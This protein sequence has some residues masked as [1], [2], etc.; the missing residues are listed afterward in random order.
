MGECHYQS[1]NYEAMVVAETCRQTLKDIGVEPER[2]SLDWASAAEAPRFV[3]LIT[4]YVKRIKG[5]GALGTGEGEEA[6]PV[7][8]RRLKAAVRAASA[9]KP[10]TSLGTLSKGL[11]K[12]GDYTPEAIEAGVA[13]KVLPAIRQQRITEEVLILLK[14]EGAMDEGHL[15][16]ATGASGDEIQKILEGLS[17]RKKIS[18]DEAGWVLMTA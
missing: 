2:L 8:D 11:H 9:R 3:E 6:K 13:K 1:G 14:E 15:A 12:G 17:R 16:E 7:I 5:M 4:G 10:R 18:Q